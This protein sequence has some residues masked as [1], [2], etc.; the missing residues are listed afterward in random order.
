[1]LYKLFSE[2]TFLFH[3]LVICMHPPPYTEKISP[4][5]RL[6][7]CDGDITILGHYF[8]SYT[9]DLYFYVWCHI[10]Y[11]IPQRFS[12]KTEYLQIEDC[13]QFTLTHCLKVWTLESMISSL[14][15][16]RYCN[17][18]WGHTEEIQWS[19]INCRGGKFNTEYWTEWH[20]S[21]V[22]SWPNFIL[23]KREIQIQSTSLKLQTAQCTADQRCWDDTACGFSFHYRWP[24]SWGDLS[25]NSES[26]RQLK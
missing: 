20:C 1:M 25:L 9:C 13:T 19:F 18:E 11:E 3:G 7:A 26:N 8:P 5:S 24:V 21:M 10:Y 16:R 23:Y 22:C 14:W 2:V 15:S 4:Q 6:K 17:R 12:G